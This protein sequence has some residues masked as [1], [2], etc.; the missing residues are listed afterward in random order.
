[1]RF[2]T[3]LALALGAL[4]VITAF[5]LRGSADLQLGR[6]TLEFRNSNYNLKTG[7]IVLTGGVSGK[8]PDGDFRADRAFGNRE[9]QEITLV[10][11]VEAHR[12]TATQTITLRSDT[13]TIDEHSRTY[14]ASGN[15]IAQVGP[16]TMSADQ[17]RLDDATRVFT[18]TG[19]VHISEPPNRSLSTTQL[20]YHDDTGDI[21]ASDPISGTT[22]NGDFRADRAQGNLKTNTLTLT[23]GVMLHTGAPQNGP[24]HEPIALYANSVFLDGATKHVDAQGD[25]KIEQGPATVTAPRMVLDNQT[26]ELRLSGGVHGDQPP[27]RTFDTTELTYNLNGGA[28]DVPKPVRGADADGSFSADKAHGNM[29]SR[30]YDL[31]GHAIVRTS[32]KRRSGPSQP[33]TTLSAPHIRVDETAKRYEAEGGVRIVQSDRTVSAPYMLFD[34]NVHIV[35]LTGG[36]H[37][38]QR[39]DRSADTAM[40]L[41]H[42]DSG[43]VLVPSQI[44]GRTSTDSFRADRALGNA[45]T[46][47]YDLVGNVVLRRQARTTSEPMVLTAHNVRING[48]AK[49]YTATGS[50]K[51]VQGTRTMTAQVMSLD[52]TTHLLRMTGGVHAEQSDGRKFDTPEVTYNIQ[53]DDFK[54]LGGVTAF[55][56]LSK[57]N[58]TPT[59]FPTPK[60]KLSPQAPSP[61][62]P[63]TTPPQF[64]SPPPTPIP[65]PTPS[66]TPTPH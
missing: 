34:D 18:L 51:V 21:F 27:D 6:F 43:D 61:F 26:G 8:G 5:P 59:P 22:E 32:G 42:T 49:T 12:K 57:P 37:A 19:V 48:R 58:A 44:T 29:K 50:P 63:G 23:G 15:V 64:A 35:R 13:A 66:A 25:V 45:K 14:V 1:M 46:D 56:P 28:F 40:V 11:N 9:R 10:G 39:P 38:T 20:V 54:M 36:V 47:I 2:R 33:P 41:Y 3:A 60:G 24:S 16:R 31:E 52:D 55:F 17:M 53:S 30:I 4:V 62:A 65:T 7:D